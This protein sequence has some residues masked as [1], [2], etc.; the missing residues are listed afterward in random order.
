M[1][2]FEYT[3]TAPE[4]IHA[5]PAGALVKTAQGFAS[6]IRISFGEKTASAAK[7]FALMKLGVKQGHTV[8]VT[9]EGTD[10]DAAIGAVAEFLKENF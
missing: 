5:R 7:L 9:A 10:E 2:T 6:E 8:T 4:G 1:K 3:I